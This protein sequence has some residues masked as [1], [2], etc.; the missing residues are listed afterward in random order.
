MF[1]ATIS[2][3]LFEEA[4]GSFCRN[5][6]FRFEPYGDS[7]KSSARHFHDDQKYR[8]YAPDDGDMFGVKDLGSAL[9]DHSWG[10]SVSPLYTGFVLHPPNAA[11]HNERENDAYFSHAPSYEKYSY[12][13]LLRSSDTM[14]G[15]RRSQ[16]AAIEDGNGHRRPSINIEAKQ[17]GS[18]YIYAPQSAPTRVRDSL[19]RENFDSI[20]E[21]TS[22]YDGVEA[23]YGHAAD[24]SAVAQN[25]RRGEKTVSFREPDDLDM[26]NIAFDYSCERF[27]PKMPFVNR[28]STAYRDAFERSSEVEIWPKMHGLTGTACNVLGN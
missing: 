10:E 18:V 6:Q 15:L 8:H 20:Q 3:T 12:P 25:P 11:D 23:T 5:K 26:K 14:A 21:G 28:A 7:N 1:L 13:D 24:E 9:A 19:D 27:Q 17:G 4:N 16:A 22:C 2:Y